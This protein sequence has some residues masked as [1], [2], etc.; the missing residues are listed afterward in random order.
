MNKLLQT[1][2]V[3]VL[4]ISGCVSNEFD[5]SL[6]DKIS[7]VGSHRYITIHGDIDYNHRIIYLD[8]MIQ[9]PL[10]AV[11][12]SILKR[13]DSWNMPMRKKLFSLKPNS[14]FTRKVYCH[15]TVTINGSPFTVI[16]RNRIHDACYG[17]FLFNTDYLISLSLE[18]DLPMNCDNL[19]SYCSSLCEVQFD[20]CDTHAVIYTRN[21]FRACDRLVNPDMSA[22]CMDNVVSTAGMFSDCVNLQNLR[23][24]GWSLT[25]VRDA[26]CMFSQCLQLRQCGV[27]NW[28]MGKVTSV[29]CMFAD[30]W[31]LP[32]LDLS[33][34]KTANLIRIDG[35]CIGCSNLNLVRLP[36]IRTPK[37]LHMEEAFLGC[38]NLSTIIASNKFGEN[39]KYYD[40]AF[41]KH[42]GCDST[43]IYLPNPGMFCLGFYIAAKAPSFRSMVSVSNIH[44]P[45]PNI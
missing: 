5:S 33:R 6:V 11:W 4:C 39:I 28:N 29:S 9:L 40:G 19:F 44:A 36:I 43:I 10:S 25:N 15:K 34:W 45:V 17:T 12:N 23:T 2:F 31:S 20:K 27:E 18:A 24:D 1:V 14:Q 38:D 42:E 3:F 30:C 37:L 41:N 22:F 16:I 8:R 32:S 26:S 13:Q 7:G 35:L 21:M